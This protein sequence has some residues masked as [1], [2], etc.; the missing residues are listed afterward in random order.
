M[1]KGLAIIYCI[2]L[3]ISL[4][5]CSREKA[6]MPSNPAFGYLRAF[7]GIFNEY[8]SKIFPLEDGS[9][10][11]VATTYSPAGTGDVPKSCRFR[12][13]EILTSLGNPED[14]FRKSDV[15]IFRVDP[16]KP[17]ERQI[18]YSRCF[19]GSGC[20][21]AHSSCITE[22]GQ[23]IVGALSES[24]DGD[25][26]GEPKGKKSWLFR[27]DPKREWSEQ[28]TYS[29]SFGEREIKQ[30][31]DVKS[32]SK[33][34]AYVYSL[35]MGNGHL[36]T[37]RIFDLSKDRR[38]NP[39]FSR[40]IL[41]SDRTTMRDMPLFV[42]NKM[43]LSDDGAATIV[44]SLDK[45]SIQNPEK[46]GAPLRINRKVSYR[47][48]KA[49]K[50][51]RSPAANAPLTD[52]G[53]RMKMSSGKDFTEY[54]DVLVLSLDPKLPKEKWITSSKILG[55]SGMDF[56]PS[57][58]KSKN[59]EFFVS[60]LSASTDG[61][62]RGAGGNGSSSLLAVFKAR[63]EPPGGMRTEP[64]GFLRAP[65]KAFLGLYDMAS[66]GG[67]KVGI[68]CMLKRQSVQ[69]ET[70]AEKAADAGSRDY[71]NVVQLKIEDPEE[72]PHGKKTGLIDIVL[73]DSEKKAAAQKNFR[74]DSDLFYSLAISGSSLF[75]MA[76]SFTPPDERDMPHYKL[77]YLES[78]LSKDS[79]SAMFDPNNKFKIS[80]LFSTELA[81]GILDV[82]NMEGASFGKG[83]AK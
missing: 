23:I 80:K 69:N 32:L 45:D 39:A 3:V 48:E 64:V 31:N 37:L 25:L 60:F 10:Y 29:Q 47:E 15:W 56:A 28:I 34:I 75:F 22:D 35:S 55:G 18:T 53:T 67:G 83:K 9:F 24:D 7:G 50:R 72:N 20:E 82:K 33:D 76:G 43:I 21:E 52:K 68:M 8:P 54:L 40:D 73:L 49:G 57:I 13:S 19:G 6:A 11:A 44:V 26:S 71:R 79:P 36:Y 16:S 41:S 78:Y 17:H 61:D 77:S 58:A 42:R 59:G 63:P 27:V 70:G 38:Q 65:E 1:K 62:L 4:S 81:V 14:L 74:V 66:D 12:T 46:G 5:S 30:I 51:D 2:F